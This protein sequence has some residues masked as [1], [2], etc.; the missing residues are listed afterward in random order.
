MAVPQGA[1]KRNWVLDVEVY[2]KDGRGRKD[3]YSSWSGEWVAGRTWVSEGGGR[4]RVAAP[5]KR[6]SGAGS[7]GRHTPLPPGQRLGT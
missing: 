4:A 1:G 5:G 6:K 7:R 2:S 3:Q